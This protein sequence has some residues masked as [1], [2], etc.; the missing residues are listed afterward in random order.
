[1]NKQL[2]SPLT[3]TE[4]VN[5]VIHKGMSL[6]AIA[7]ISVENKWLEHPYY[8]ILEGRR[9]NVATKIKVGEYA[10]KPGTTPL[11]MLDLLVSG[12]VIQYSITI[13]EGYSFYQIMK[14]VDNNKFIQHTITDNAPASIAAL[15]DIPYNTPEGLFYPDTYHFPK[16]TPDI[17]FLKRAYKI[18]DEILVAE[19]EKRS[20]GLPYKNVY[21]ALIMA[22]INEKE[23]AVPEEYEKI[24]GVFV[25]RLKKGM[26]LQT[27]PTVIYALGLAFDGDIRRKDLSYDSPYNTYVY[28]GLPPSP[29]ASPGQVSIHAALHP[30]DGTALYFVAKGDG[31]H[32]FSDSLAKHNRAVSKYQLKK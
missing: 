10:I 15:L 28:R 13:P 5:L 9:R 17:E 26:K 31:N 8:L 23:T 25:R 30:E 19:W 21:E 3:I 6:S 18:M 4:E 24:A 20:S 29:I 16:A 7:N 2:N 22:S 27:D 14:I 32:Y 11:Q 12:K 1:M